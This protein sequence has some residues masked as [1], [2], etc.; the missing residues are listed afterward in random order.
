[1][2]FCKT[3]KINILNGKDVVLITASLNDGTNIQIT[4][5]GGIVHAWQC[6]DKQGNLADILLGRA[7]VNG[8]F[9]A[10]PYF[11]AVTGRFANRIAYGK[12]T[13]DGKEYQLSTNLSPHHL[14]GGFC[15]LDKK[16]WDYAIEELSGHVIITLT[17]S[18]PHLEEGFPGNLLVKVQ[19]TYTSENELIIRYYAET[20]APTP[21]NL[22]NHCYFNLSGNQASDILDH[23]IFI[24]ADAITEVDASLL[25]T[26][27]YLNI[28]DTVLD[29]KTSKKIGDQIFKDDPLLTNAKGYDHNFIL[30]ISD[31]HQA[32]AV[33]IHEPSGRRLQIFTDQPAIQLYTGNHLNNTLGKSGIYKDYSGFCLE[34][35][36]FPNSPNHPHFP[37]T[38]LRPDEQFFSQTIYKMD[39]II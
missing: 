28:K 1:M 38:I 5:F 34:T 2:I 22:T 15:G 37:N 30:N 17:T 32:K 23:Y 7:N 21:I 6:F 29:F 20:D 19:Y 27:E 3:E 16:V 18:S 8:Y 39:V 9:D 25:P 10:H 36:H 12:F 14:H 26:G 35:Q 13:L 11:G 4:N 33:A 31:Q 24:D